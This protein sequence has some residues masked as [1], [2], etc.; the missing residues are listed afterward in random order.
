MLF[1]DS[2]DVQKCLPQNAEFEFEVLKPF[3]EQQA[4]PKLIIPNLGK[5]LYE[6]LSTAAKNNDLS[7]K[8]EEL[9]DKVRW[10]AANYAYLKYLPFSTTSRGKGGTKRT[11]DERTKTP[12][13][14]QMVGMENSC[15]EAAYDGIE[16]LLLF[17]E[18][19]IDEGEFSDW[20]DSSAFTYFRDCFI[21]TAT[22]FSEY[23]EIG[24]SR[25]TFLAMRSI[26]REMEDTR[27]KGVLGKEF[28]AELK[29][30]TK[31]ADP[32]DLTD[33]NKLVIPY[34]NRAIANATIAKAAVKLPVRITAD[35]FQLIST[36][37]RMTLKVLNPADKD[38]LNA[39]IKEANESGDNYLQ[40][41]K[42]FLYDNIDDY[43]TFEDGSA[44]VDP[45]SDDAQPFD[46]S[47]NGVVGI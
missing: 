14:Y 40:E 27:I 37:D 31:S 8:M 7:E 12:F 35:G 28:Y 45:D 5:D 25:R 19:N 29:E 4:I 41:L 17:L 38:S 11:E 42:D 2:S 39:I 10:P 36:S 23:Y 43:P 47:E 13:E 22:E 30:Q 33:E 32:V 18:E 1:S 46:Q 16:Q 34:I 9:L 21:K 20:K 15:H 3:I 44:Y 26:M 24:S 6:A